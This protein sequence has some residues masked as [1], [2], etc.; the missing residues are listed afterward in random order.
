MPFRSPDW[1]DRKSDANRFVDARTSASERALILQR[2][3]PTK[4]LLPRS[5]FLVLDALARQLGP[6]RFRS[7]NYALW[8]SDQSAGLRPRTRDERDRYPASEK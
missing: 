5:H 6:P 4:V 1:S 7:D 2:R 3:T 8:A